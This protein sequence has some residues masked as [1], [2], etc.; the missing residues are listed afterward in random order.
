MHTGKQTLLLVDDKPTNLSV[1]AE[2][3]AHKNFR[4]LTA[5]S[6]ERA[7]TILPHAKPDIILLD[8]MMPGLDG[9]ET[10]QQIKNN[11][12]YAHIPIIFLSALNDRNEKVKGFALG[13]VDYITKPLH[14]EEVLARI[15]THLTISKLRL[16]LEKKVKQLD[17]NLHEREALIEDLNAYAKTVAHDLKNPVNVICGMADTLLESLP[18][19]EPEI[20]SRRTKSIS[21]ASWKLR[22]I[23]EELL[24]FATVSRTDITRGT[25]EMHPIVLQALAR[26]TNLI[27]EKS[28]KI[29]IQETF[30]S[31]YGNPQWIEEVW[32][33]Y[34]QNALKYAGSETHIEVGGKIDEYNNRILYWV[35]DNGESMT[36]DIAKNIFTQQHKPKADNDEDNHG[37]GL[38][39][40][41]RII[42]KLN[43][44]VWA[45][46]SP[47]KG[48]TFYFS[49]NRTS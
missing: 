46:S 29:T 14:Q 32:F 34:L 2:Y 7:L 11:P 8:I 48:S 15:Q 40:V 12:A 20:I 9:F 16:E 45:E 1:L 17:Q 26:L 25:I 27:Q 31:A 24:V 44:S 3:L 4:V 49:L 28:A 21:K 6:G 47:N 38:S 42:H 36:E 30:P 43:G 19:L 18:G 13:A 22:S 23:I 35:H 41:K 39:I 33:N 10:C 5:E 37:L